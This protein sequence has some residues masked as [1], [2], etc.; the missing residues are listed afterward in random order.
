MSGPR[1]AQHE[2]SPRQA[3][4]RLCPAA[5]N[6]VFGNIVYTQ[7][8]GPVLS[9]TVRVESWCCPVASR[10]GLIDSPPR[11]S[12]RPCSP[13]PDVV[14]C[15][16]APSLLLTIFKRIPLHSPFSGRSD[17]PPYLILGLVARGPT[18]SHQHGLLAIHSIHTVRTRLLEP[19]DIHPQL[20]RGG[21]PRSMLVSWTRSF[22][23]RTTTPQAT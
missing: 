12:R 5:T 8:P 13:H 4:L 9:R 14:T 11:I 6:M 22:T 17:C 7:R 1:A 16:S 20:V 10:E 21:T 15:M 19:C 2:H 23:T 3:A 18:G